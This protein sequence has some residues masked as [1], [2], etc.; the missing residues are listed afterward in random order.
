MVFPLKVRLTSRVN[1]IDAPNPVSQTDAKIR[2]KF[3]FNLLRQQQIALLEEPELS[4]SENCP[5]T[6][7]IPVRAF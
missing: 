1:F 3:L 4:E 2:P 7:N 6:G 5:S